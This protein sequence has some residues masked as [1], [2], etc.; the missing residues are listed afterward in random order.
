MGFYLS[1][2]N[3]PIYGSNV[4]NTHGLGTPDYL[5]KVENRNLISLTVGSNA[6]V[7]GYSGYGV[8]KYGSVQGNM[9]VG[10]R[11]IL[12]LDVAPSSDNFYVNVTLST[13]DPFTLG[14]IMVRINGQDYEVD[15]LASTFPTTSGTPPNEY[16][17]RVIYKNTTNLTYNPFTSFLGL[18]TPV[19]V[20]YV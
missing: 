15:K 8:T 14:K 19:V 9:S 17:A 2:K 20:W 12:A 6:A 11:S 16:P 7:Y 3:S 10:G 1:S 18:T 5:S 4:L 13:P